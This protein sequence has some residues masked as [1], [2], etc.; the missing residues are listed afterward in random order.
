MRFSSLTLVVAAL[1]TNGPTW[2]DSQK[3]LWQA[4]TS[5]STES[6]DYGSNSKTSTVYVPFSLRRLFEAGSLELIVPFI[7]VTSDGDVLIVGGVAHST[8]NGGKN[9]GGGTTTTPRVTHS[10]LG[11][12][13]LKGHYNALEEGTW[14]PSVEAVAKIKFPTASRSES[15]GTGKFDEGVDLEFCKT[16]APRTLA[17]ADAGYTFI[18]SP[19]GS[20]L[21]NQWN[22]SLGAGYY[23]LPEQLLAS[24]IYEET[25]ALVADESNPKNLLLEA[26][27]TVTPR[28]NVQA[29]IQA[30]LSRSSADY[31]LNIGA[32]LKF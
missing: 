12:V 5:V 10:G 19:P 22:F 16:I 28:F 29:G 31:G 6:G 21:H 8:K 25:A 11:D 26:D 24:L 32:R 13:V 30:G 17:L 14:T 18:G 1:L 3:P 2:A 15:L 20:D 7:S 9:G 4:G 27:Y 23:V